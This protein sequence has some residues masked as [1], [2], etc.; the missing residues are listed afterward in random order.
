MKRLLAAFAAILASGAVA[1]ADP[2]VTDW[3]AVLEDARGQTVYWNAWGGSESIN[4]Y[5]D[6]VGETGEDRHGVRLVG[7]VSGLRLLSCRPDHRQLQPARQHVAANLADSE[8]P[9]DGVFPLH[10]PSH[11]P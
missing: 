1:A 7:S 5:I 11:R 8:R 2:D 6:W 10:R 4:A 3:D 9:D